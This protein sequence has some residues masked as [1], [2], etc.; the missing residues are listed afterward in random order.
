MITSAAPSFVELFLP[1]C[2]GRNALS[3]L[4]PLLTGLSTTTV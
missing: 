1:A 4:G 3:V 2:P